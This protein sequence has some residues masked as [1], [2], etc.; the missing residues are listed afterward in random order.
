MAVIPSKLNQP[1][2]YNKGTHIRLKRSVIFPE[3][4]DF[5]FTVQVKIIP[6]GNC[7]KYIIKDPNVMSKARSFCGSSSETIQ[8]AIASCPK[9]AQN[10]YKHRHRGA[11]FSIRNWRNN[12]LLGNLL[13]VL[14]NDS[15]KLYKDHTFLMDKNVPFNRPDIT[16]ADKTNKKAAFIDI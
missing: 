2:T 9:L 12:H 11:K 5:I 6:I 8:R 10:A 14:E 1:G 15:Y 4:E 7:L 16:L 3:T 13:V